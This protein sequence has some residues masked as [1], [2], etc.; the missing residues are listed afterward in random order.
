MFSRIL[1][2]MTVWGLSEVCH[3]DIIDSNREREGGRERQSSSFSY[4][5]TSTNVLS[6][7]HEGAYSRAQEREGE[8]RAHVVAGVP[9]L[10]NVTKM[11]GSQP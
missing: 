4:Y 1:F 10:L 6:P 2:I 9:N 5:E 7:N 8:K 11:A 3:Q